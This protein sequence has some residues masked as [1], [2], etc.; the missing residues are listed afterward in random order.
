MA[1][2]KMG[3]NLQSGAGFLAKRVQKSL[4]R[5]QEKVLQKLG[6]TMETKDEHFEVCS[7]NLHKQQVDGTRLLK[8]VKA[9]FGAVKA[10]HETSKRLSQTLREVY[11]PD[12]DGIEDLAVIIESEDLLWNDYEE[13]MNDQIVRTMENYTSQF[14]EVKE[15]V[16]KRGRKLVDYDSARHHLES[17][18]SAKKK[19]DGKIA[20]AEEEFNK[21]Q[22]VFEEINNELREEMPAL[23]QSRIGCYVTVFQNVSNLRDVFY[24]E[25]SVL[26]RDLYNVMKKLENQHS[27]KAFII[28]GLSSP[29]RKSK[30]RRSL[31]ISSPIPCNTAF[32]A[33]HISIN[34]TTQNGDAVA[35]TSP[36]PQTQSI[37]SDIS[38]EE[39]SG[40][41]TQ[42]GVS[43]DSDLSSCDNSTHHRQSV[44]VSEPSDRSTSE[45]LE[46]VEAEAE[47]ST[48][49]CESGVSKSEVSSEE[50]AIPSDCALSDAPHI[51]NQ[52][53]NASEAQSE[54]VKTK[55]AP[56]PAPRR[57]FR[58]EKDLFPSAMENQE[59]TKGDFDTKMSAGSQDDCDGQYPPGFLYKRVAL[60]SH[61]EPE[62]GQLQFEEGDIILVF[63]DTQKEGLVRGVKEE[64]WQLHRDLENHAGTFSEDFIGPVQAE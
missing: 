27:G 59:E 37:S 46:E 57:S 52:E 64:N 54:E 60:K 47:L 30:K 63:A 16:S 50:S 13:K 7:Q 23:Y 22:N 6:K 15:R 36:E 5:A 45:S 41:P 25:M 11:E 48:N 28:K 26:N 34:F 21:A 40:I 9:Y 35:P 33:D 42:I 51:P 44:C 49:Q 32:P 17:L 62:G 8:D 2:N 53:D 18:Q 38:R 20:K 58:S 14:P 10:L 19:D 24:K 3:P 39:D 31:A 61:A 1:D 29:K 12:W 4:N 43:S 56:I 55:N